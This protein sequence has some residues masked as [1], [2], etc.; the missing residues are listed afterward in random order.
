VEQDAADGL[1]KR[2]AGL[3]VVPAKGDVAPLQRAPISQLR[4]TSAIHRRDGDVTG[5]EA[6]RDV[7]ALLALDNDHRGVG[8]LGEQFEPVERTRIGDV[9]PAPLLLSSLAVF[10]PCPG[11]ELLVAVGL[12]VAADEANPVAI[13]VAIN[14]HRDRIAED[15]V[16]HAR[17]RNRVGNGNDEIPIVV[18]G[19]LACG[20]ADSLL[21]LVLRQG[22]E[23]IVIH[24][25]DLRH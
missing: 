8:P 15:P 23:A 19:A 22:P 16:T 7:G 11:P 2:L 3:I 5:K 6:A 21:A 25:D 1:L 18:F 24:G 9:L 10:P 12:V 4:R 20:A 13:P 14:P 17:S